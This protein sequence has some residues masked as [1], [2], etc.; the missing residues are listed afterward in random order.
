MDTLV[1]SGSLTK[2]IN[3]VFVPDGYQASEM[4]LFISRANQ[5]LKSMLA[6]SPFLEYQQYFNAFAIQVPSPESGSTH[7]RTAPDCGSTQSFAAS[8][9]F[10][11]TF[12]VGG[13][14]R[15]LVPQ[16]NAALSVVLAQNFP[17]YDQVFVLVNSTE[18]GGSG[19]FVATASANNNATEIA[20][21]EIG[22]SFAGL[23]DEYWAGP[24]YAHETFNMTQDTNPATVRWAS[25]IGTNSV[26][27]YPH[28][29]DPR[30]QKP[31]LSCKMQYLGLP[32]C[33]VCKEAFVERI[34]T[35]VSPLQAYSP[36]T[37]AINSPSQDV[38]FALTLLPPTPNT[39]KITW[40]RDGT[41]FAQNA[42]TATVALAQLPAGTHTVRALVVDTTA[43]TRVVSHAIQHTYTVDWT[44]TRTVTGIRMASATAVYKVEM[45]P[46]PVGDVLT[47]SYQLPRVA[48]V[49]ITVLDAAGRKVKTVRYNRQ[50]AGR[51]H[52]QLR[53][54]ELGIREAGV[55]TLLLGMDGIPITRQLV[56]Q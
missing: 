2:R 45:Y 7:P 37:L 13:I 4:P 18:Y 35:L 40:T 50:A 8:T 19:G 49:S 15:L 11:S 55:Y 30:W 27:I 34:H 42:A 22:H 51:Y 32:F 9:Y 53:P 48:P 10:N 3:L 17:L 43:L 28:A 31:H 12:D 44:I 39:L 41:V 21:H 38:S 54:E 46:N 26:G 56:K 16:Q 25:W 5:A 24:Q 33:A 52:Y 14:H 29:V 47:L 20:I 36:T 1:K 6:Q 23:A